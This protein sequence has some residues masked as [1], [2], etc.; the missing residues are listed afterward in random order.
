MANAVVIL[1]AGSSHDFGVPTLNGIFE[2]RRVRDYLEDHPHFAEMLRKVFWEPRGHTR[3]TAGGS[4][5]VEEMLTILRD[6]ENEE[7]VPD[8]PAPLHVPVFR[9]HLYALIERAVHR[10]KSSNHGRHM[11]PLISYCRE[12]FDRTTWA[13]FNW[14]CIFEASYYYSSGD[15]PILGGH[16]SNPR[17]AIPIE[18]WRGGRSRE[19]AARGHELLNL[20]GSVSWWLRP[21]EEAEADYR[22]RSYQFGTEVREKFEA[23][24]ADADPDEVPA[25]LEPSFHKYET[26]LYEL[27]EPQWERF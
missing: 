20:H 18:G 8:P 13:S 17:V 10:G 16:R 3:E 14:D 23:Y 21:N 9:K 27:L 2:D 4:I 26:D 15:P 11:N 25:I 19:D 7:Q 12:T 24:D 6:W 5:N 22:I 1:G